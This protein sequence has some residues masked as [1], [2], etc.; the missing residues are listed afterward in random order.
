MP[1]VGVVGEVLRSEL[2]VREMYPNS[3]CLEGEA[4]SY[5]PSPVL[6]E[7]RLYWVNDRGIAHC[8]NAKTAHLSISIVWILKARAGDLFMPLSW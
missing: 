8:I 4:S 5:V 2:V 1:S 7:D 6:Y 3:C